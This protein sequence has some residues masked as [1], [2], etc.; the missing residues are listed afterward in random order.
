MSIYLFDKKKKYHNKTYIF[1]YFDKFFNR[2]IKTYCLEHLRREFI[3]NRHFGMIEG[4][5]KEKNDKQI[6]QIQKE[7]IKNRTNLDD[8]QIHPEIYQENELEEFK[9]QYNRIFLKNL[10]NIRSIFRTYFIFD[11]GK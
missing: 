6:L 10:S 9:F 8:N 5:N 7:I 11:W 3:G 2:Y 4:L 1:H